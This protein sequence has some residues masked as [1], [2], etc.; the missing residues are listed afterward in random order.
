MGQGVLGRH[1]MAL[2]QLRQVP[3]LLTV[4]QRWPTWKP[5]PHQYLQVY[6]SPRQL[7]VVAD[8]RE[9]QSELVWYFEHN[10]PFFCG[11]CEVGIATGMHFGSK[12]LLE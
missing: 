6:Q 4:A 10:D 11:E 1:E 7:Q 12:L 3:G 8:D 2:C 5:H 9:G